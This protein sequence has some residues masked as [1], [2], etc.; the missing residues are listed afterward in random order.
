MAFLHELFAQHCACGAPVKV[1]LINA[2]NSAV[3]KFCK[4][5]G[6]RALKKALVDEKT[7]WESL[8]PKDPRP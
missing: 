1:E 7:W 3:G 2:R 5:C 8:K 6:A 4:R